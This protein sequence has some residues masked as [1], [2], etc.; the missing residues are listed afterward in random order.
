MPYVAVSCDSHVLRVDEIY[1]GAGAY[2]LYKSCGWIYVE[3]CA[4]YNEDVGL[5]CLVYG[6]FYHGNALAE[7]YDVRTEQRAVTCR[8]AGLHLIIVGCQSLP[9][10]PVLCVAA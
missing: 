3:G 9:E 10:V 1:R 7:E 5:L 8:G 4:Y 2:I 6:R